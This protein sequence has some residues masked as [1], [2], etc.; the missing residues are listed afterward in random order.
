MKISVQRKNLFVFAFSGFLICLAWALAGHAQ[1]PN[2]WEPVPADELSFATVPMLPDARAVLLFRQIRLN[3]ESLVDS[4]HVRIKV[5]S[6]AG[7][8][9]ADV[10]VPESKG[11]MKVQD[12][13]ARVVSPDGS[14]RE[15]SGPIYDRMMV[16][17][18]FVKFQVKVL[19]LP[20][21]SVG[22]IIEYKYKLKWDGYR[23]FGN[24]WQIQDELYTRRALFSILP[25]SGRFSLVWAGYRLPTPQRPQKQP[26]GSFLM[27]LRDI[28]PFETEPFM[29]PEAE[30]KA[31]VQFFYTLGQIQPVEEYWN[32]AGKAFR[33]R[34]ENFIGKTKDVEKTALEIVAASDPPEAKLRK[35]YAW[36]QKLH[37]RT[38]DKARTRK[39][40]KELEE[41]MN[42]SAKDTIRNGSGYRTEINGT[43]VA[44]ARAIGL[45]AGMFSIAPR[46][47]SFFNPSL[48]DAS[49][50]NDEVAWVRIEDKEWLLDPGLRFCPF[51]LL[52]WVDT[53]T[54]GM[55]IE[56]DTAALAQVPAP[57]SESA[58]VERAATL[59]LRAD[60]SVEGKV[61]IRYHGQ[62]ALIRR[63]ENARSTPEEWKSNLETEWKGFFPEDAKIKFASLQGEQLTEEPL[64]AEF[65]VELPEFGNASARRL[66][67]PST[68]F[69]QESRNP[70]RATKR[71]HPVYLPFPYQERDEIHVTLPEGYKLEA[72]PEPKKYASR[73][74]EYQITRDETGEF[75]IQR[76]LSVNGFYFPASDYLGVRRLFEM[77]V[78]GD[79]DQI[80]LLAPVAAPG[81]PPAGPTS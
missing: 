34:L 51:G 30:L 5:L 27:E 44:L 24:L 53:G 19:T 23:L 40:G 7:R 22:S 2:A 66:L 70:F 9:Y 32:G 62:E 77:I 39:D 17:S 42:L 37:N 80:I 3:D 59:K 68:V 35:L 76:A 33:A 61:K 15:F 65:D 45:R 29:P 50:L 81:K 4:Y 26:D 54:Q 16:K 63:A 18:K 8:S 78:S 57:Q 67:V 47:D 55:R 79:Q 46:R 14:A 1:S 36:T 71:S 49:Q 72:F 28:L 20:D 10:F 6:E 38:Y 31:T 74:G 12:L 21:V 58:L 41:K 13:K 52:H 75:K 11:V 25:R 43:L 56:G 48:R 64:V 69:Y 73:F 60:G